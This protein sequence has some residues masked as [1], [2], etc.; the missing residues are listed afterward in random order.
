MKI[1]DSTLETVE[2]SEIDGIELGAAL[3]YMAIPKKSK[4]H[5]MLE[6]NTCVGDLYIIVNALYDYA[7]ILERVAAQQASYQKELY[8][9]HAARCRKIA[10]KFS[11]QMGYDYDKALERCRKRRD[12]GSDDDT[13]FDG[14]EAAIRKKREGKCNKEKKL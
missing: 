10:G 2:M 8:L 13:G 4:A 11:E 12:K 14:L 9:L 6:L 5:E 3:R 7:G 1:T